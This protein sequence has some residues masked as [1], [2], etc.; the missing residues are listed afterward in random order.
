MNDENKK[1]NELND[2]LNITE[3]EIQTP[4][5][6]ENFLEELIDE[7]FNSDDELIEINEIDESYAEKIKSE[8]K[9]KAKKKA[10][11]RK[12]QN[13]E[14]A[15]RN[16]EAQRISKEQ[17][18][19][20]LN[21]KSQKIDYEEDTYQNNISDSEKRNRQYFDDDKE[22]EDI[23]KKAEQQARF[24][25]IKQAQLERRERAENYRS[26]G[27]S[28]IDF[29]GKEQHSAYK[30]VIEENK[31]DNDNNY[32]SYENKNFD[33]EIKNE[34]QYHKEDFKSSDDKIKPETAQES[35]TDYH[36]N[37]K[38][39]ENKSNY[40]HY[41]DKK[42]NND[43]RP[44]N[45]PYKNDYSSNNETQK[46]EY[47]TPSHVEN[48][49]ANKEEFY[50]EYK[51]YKD[52]RD[53]YNSRVER[54]ENERK[55]S[56]SSK[57]YGGSINHTTDYKEPSRPNE[58]RKNYNNENY[59]EPKRRTETKHEDVVHKDNSPKNN[60]HYKDAY[61]NHK[62]ESQRREDDF[63]SRNNFH[64]EKPR[65]EDFHSSKYTE[66]RDGTIKPSP[67]KHNDN[68]YKEQK[69]HVNDNGF[70]RR[71][72]NHYENT[73]SKGSTSPKYHEIRDDQSKSSYKPD[74]PRRNINREH[75]NEEKSSKKYTGSTFVHQEHPE[76]EHNNVQDKTKAYKE[77]VLNN[78]ENKPIVD[79]HSSDYKNS[80][81]Y[82]KINDNFSRKDDRKIPS[83]T[84]YSQIKNEINYN[85][86]SKTPDGEKQEHY[87]HEVRTENKIKQAAV[88]AAGAS[89]Y[90]AYT[91]YGVDVVNPVTV[92]EVKKD[93]YD[94][95]NISHTHQVRVN[96][97]AN[98]SFI[99]KDRKL[100]IKSDSAVINKGNEA[101]SN[102]IDRQKKNAISPISENFK[103]SKEFPKGETFYFNKKTDPLTKKSESLSGAKTIESKKSIRMAHAQRLGVS[104]SSAS[105]AVVQRIGRQ[106]YATVENEESGT[107]REAEKI[108]RVMSMGGSSISFISGSVIQAH[109][110]YAGVSHTMTRLGNAGRY[111][112]GLDLNT[113]EKEIKSLQNIYGPLTLDQSK[114]LDYLL[115]VQ[116]NSQFKTFKPMSVKDFDK[117]ISKFG[118]L[119]NMSV[120]NI[121]KEINSLKKLKVLTADQ[122]KKL[123]TLTE[124]L[125]LKTKRG[126]ASRIL[127]SQKNFTSGL[128]TSLKSV[129]K[130]NE[131]AGIDGL[132]VTTDF[133]S[134]R[135]VRTVM[136]VSYKFSALGVRSTLR[137]TGKAASYIG[138]KTG[139]TP[140]IANS[141]VVQGTKHTVNRIKT[142]VNGGIYN[143]AKNKIAE[144]TP[145]RIKTA[146]NK[147]TS[148]A[149]ATKAVLEKFKKSKLGSGISKGVEMVSKPFKAIGN[150]F[151]LVG[152]AKGL[153]LSYLAIGLG[154]VAL[155]YF[156]LV[157][158][159]TLVVSVT[160]V[161]MTE[162]P[163]VQKY[164]DYTL[165]LQA[166]YEEELEAMIADVRE[167]ADSLEETT[168]SYIGKP[169]ISNGKEILSMAAVYNDQD[170]PQWYEPFDNNKMKKYIK[171]LY[172]DTHYYT[173]NLSPVYEC[174]GCKTDTYYCA[175]ENCSGHTY[176]YCTGH[177]EVEV[178]LMTYTFDDIFYA[179][180]I[181]SVPDADRGWTGW[182]EGNREWCKNLYNQNWFDLYGVSF[183]GDDFF[184]SPLSAIEE[185]EIWAN[186]NEQYPDLSAERK[187]L[188]SSA[189]SLVGRVPY[190]WGGGHHT[191]LSPDYDQAWGVELR[192]VYADGNRNQ[193]KGTMHLYGLDC[194]GFTRWSILNSTGSDTMNGTAA[195][196]ERFGYPVSRWGNLQ[197]GDFAN[198]ADDGH[199][200]IYLYT[201]DEG[202]M[203]FVHCSPSVNGVGI[204]APGYFTSF[205]RPRGIL[206]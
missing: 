96:G 34:R 163:N 36:K 141:K 128:A 73:R 85:T 171:K 37:I 3:S 20:N 183:G 154:V 161:F 2:E 137:T 110:A 105:G 84:R 176:W 204:N 19:R 92:K 16:D 133:L 197:P 68:N 147:A 40:N 180:T 78:R 177:Q 153:F 82:H 39:S 121:K 21:N 45:E 119:G 115:K 142:G 5:D 184:P 54:Y 93:F 102:Y 189:L 30:E 31:Y 51:D 160:S 206:S 1:P 24:E 33:K 155:I 72:E 140:K 58:E 100:F 178:I 170:W 144:K 166:L 146:V 6:N 143:A 134:N 114:R 165:E 135:Y 10:R 168:Y 132:I 41:D 14:N 173:F 138:N 167:E 124:L 4:D 86:R 196:Q 89:T 17:S 35:K 192:E 186:I 95:L 109:T 99:E 130:D 182:D 112:K 53:D 12:R 101:S 104:L 175:A 66:R 120:F 203:V 190:F 198:T 98:A 202:Q 75:Y 164:A 108:K 136:K 90:S 80:E 205:Y 139:I 88:F 152:R 28:G 42:E 199:V 111:I 44:Q 118:T 63:H 23:A 169:S 59:N 174:D 76:V 52:S 194:S 81:G 64:E 145:V 172:Y 57:I 7:V 62:Y 126:D 32:N 71:E 103:N 74:E 187:A 125:L 43:Y 83:N 122:E 50:K 97:S 106:I 26:I 179:D 159:L 55:E 113:V 61:E 185:A 148:R 156:I 8:K 107:L 9:A 70:S 200:G 79:N 69:N 191:N 22:K 201:N 15:R 94:R 13:E 25:R 27:N 181:G 116:K 127:A 193:P 158:F 157:I 77:R 38:Y 188:I 149:N 47:K 91:P 49:R 60:N 29:S 67:F 18:E 131:S 56:S 150:S 48:Q 123:N 151:N 162:V 129:F 87:R 65:R 11:E 46:D 195:Y 117:S